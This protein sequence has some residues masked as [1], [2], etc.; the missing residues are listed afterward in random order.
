M[1]REW[2]ISREEFAYEA[3]FRQAVAEE[4]ARLENLGH[5]VGGAVIATPVRVKS[6]GQVIRGIDEYETVA[7]VFQ[8]KFMPAAR[9]E[10]P[11][12][13]VSETPTEPIEAPGVELEDEDPVRSLAGVE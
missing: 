9:R 4:L 8:H 2:Q 7:W 10:D 3:D 5:R 6:D 1:A 12:V 11:P 13:A